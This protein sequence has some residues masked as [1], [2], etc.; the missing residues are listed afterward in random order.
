[1]NY[2]YPK[3]TRTLP[4]GL[5]KECISLAPRLLSEAGL[6]A[7]NQRFLSKL[8]GK[9]GL[10]INGSRVHFDPALVE[11]NIAEYAEKKRGELLAEPTTYNKAQKALCGT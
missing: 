10:K 3:Y 9:S 2:C 8:S 6:K 4:E 11:A 5:I 7:E 1:M